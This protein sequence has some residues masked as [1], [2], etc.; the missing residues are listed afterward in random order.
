MVVVDGS[1]RAR[2]HDDDV[3]AG[4]RYGYRLRIRTPD[5]DRI[6]GETWLVVPASVS[7]ALRPL[8]NP[9]T[10]AIPGVRITLASDAPAHVDLV[11]LHGRR[12][13]REAVG[14]L[15]AGSHELR[16]P[17][18]QERLGEGVILVRLTQSGH[19]ITRKLTLI[20]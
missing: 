5:G 6:A 9:V 13:H 14:H 10:D 15:G 12:I 4:V 16:F 2:H 1:G 17:R 11:D 19:S 8:Q 7:F 18:L 20:R 3:I